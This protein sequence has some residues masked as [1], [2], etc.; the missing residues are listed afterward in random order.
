MLKERYKPFEGP[1]YHMSGVQEALRVLS[2]PPAAP[3][4]CTSLDQTALLGGG[5]CGTQ[6]RTPP[7]SP[8]GAVLPKRSASAG[9][10]LHSLPISWVPPAGAGPFSS[11]RSQGPFYNE[12][13][14]HAFSYAFENGSANDTKRRDP[15]RKAWERSAG[16]AGGSRSQS[17][18]APAGE[19]GGVRGCVLHTPSTRTRF[20]KARW[21]PRGPAGGS[22]RTR[23]AS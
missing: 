17:K 5:A 4:R 13:G 14:W 16:A 2:E 8:V 15:R 12:E 1:L 9:C 21:R 10:S 11:C 18:T 23:S 7:G 6:L 20:G 19:P 3:L 22:E